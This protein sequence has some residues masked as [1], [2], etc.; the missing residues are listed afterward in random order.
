[1]QQLRNQTRSHAARIDC[2]FLKMMP[3]GKAHGVLR[4]RL[5]F[6]KKMVSI[7]VADDDLSSQ[8][9]LRRRLARLGRITC[10]ADGEQALEVLRNDAS[11]KMAILAWMMPGLDGYQICQ[12]VKRWKPG[13]YVVL[14]VGRAFLEDGKHLAPDANDYLAKPFELADIDELILRSK[15]SS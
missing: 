13:L 9:F 11:V 12:M 1:M 15:I 5:R 3:G 10:V 2:L 7:L 6:V 14:M 4:Q 8:D